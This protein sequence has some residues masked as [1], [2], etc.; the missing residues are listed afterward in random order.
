MKNQM[1][2]SK[3]AQILHSDYP[4]ED[5]L[6]ELQEIK[7]QFVKEDRQDEAK[8][9]W[10]FQTI[11]RIHKLYRS[12]FQLLKS[13]QYYQGWCELEKLEITYHNLKRHISFSNNEYLLS[14]IE[15]CLLNL[16]VIFPYKLFASTEMVK[17]IISCS[18]CKKTTSIRNFCGHEVGEIYDGEMC[19]RIVEKA[20][21]LAISL[22][23]DPGNKYAVMFLKDPQTDQQVDQYNYDTIDVLMKNLD[24]PYEYWDLEVSERE[25][26]LLEFG[27]LGRNELCKCSSGR[28]FKKCCLNKIG[29]KYPHYE[30]IL[31]KSIARES[32]L[33]NTQKASH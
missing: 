29:Q 13:K 24:S 22:V 16:Q 33:T 28:K 14:T 8:K 10:I 2:P 15:K 21:I 32:Y 4:F 7:L 11:I 19:Y 18:V 30:F 17:T 20:E 6:A 9:V 27:K 31:K 5:T 26:S 23:E 1:I 3:L 12:A 25:L